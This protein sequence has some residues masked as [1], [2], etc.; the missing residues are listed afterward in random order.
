MAL[1]PGEANDYP[2]P[3]KGYE[4]ITFAEG[5]SSVSTVVVDTMV[6]ATSVIRAVARPTFDGAEADD[7][8]MDPVSVHIGALTAGTS[9][10]L[11]AIPADERSSP[12]GTY[13]V[14]YER[15]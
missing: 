4:D 6:Q 1:L 11:V 13:R 7:M 2:A 12:I 8:E 14:H 3:V 10:T 5:D 15:W 9:F